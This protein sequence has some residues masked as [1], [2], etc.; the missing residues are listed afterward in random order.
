MKRKQSND[1]NNENDKDTEINKKDI[2]FFEI[3]EKK[4]MNF[5]DYMNIVNFDQ[6]ENIPIEDIAEYYKGLSAF[7]L[8]K[9]CFDDEYCIISTLAGGLIFLKLADGNHVY[10]SNFSFI[11]NNILFE[12]FV[13]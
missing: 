3:T 5:D 10:L 2:S 12:V 6:G 7:C 8:W 13:L 1:E 9:N 11:F 4:L